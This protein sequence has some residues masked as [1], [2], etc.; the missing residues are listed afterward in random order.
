[1]NSASGSLALRRVPKAKRT[2]SR[3]RSISETQ[4]RRKENDDLPGYLPY[5]LL[6]G[7]TIFAFGMPFFLM[8][9]DGL[10]EPNQSFYPPSHGVDYPSRA[11]ADNPKEGVHFESGILEYE[12]RALGHRHARKHVVEFT[13]FFCEHC[14]E[15]HKHVVQPIIKDYVPGRAR[16]ESHPVAFLDDDS[17]SA[18]SAALCGQEQHKYWEVRELLFQADLTEKHKEGKEIFDVPMLRRIAVLAGLDMTAFAKCYHSRRYVDEV[19]RISQLARNLGIHATPTF[20]INNKKHEG[21]VS[22]ETVVKL[23]GPKPV[24]Q[25]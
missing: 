5:I 11:V 24:P 13:D 8:F 23:L 12:G 10:P 14:Q 1:M 22:E 4:Q 20:M 9:F 3:L 6:G 21:L 7:A 25:T 17:L 16:L 19:K 15:A 2:Q 18:A